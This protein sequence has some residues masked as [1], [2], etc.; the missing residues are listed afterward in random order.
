MKMLDFRYV[1]WEMDAGLSTILLAKFR[2]DNTDL[3][4]QL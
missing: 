4:K 3:L 2:L 1:I